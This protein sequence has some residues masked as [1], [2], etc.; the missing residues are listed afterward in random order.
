[1]TS[2]RYLAQNTCVS[3]LYLCMNFSRDKIIPVPV[4]VLNTHD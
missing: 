3:K 2:L 4:S 1:M